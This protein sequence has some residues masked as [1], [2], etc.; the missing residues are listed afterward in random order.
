MIPESFRGYLLM[1]LFILNISCETS[2][3]IKIFRV[4]YR[5]IDSLGVC[6]CHIRM[7]DVE[8]GED[9]VV[10]ITSTNEMYVISN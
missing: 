3:D 10:C 8:V 1:Y 6:E 2:N 7:D 4:E 9:S 5:E